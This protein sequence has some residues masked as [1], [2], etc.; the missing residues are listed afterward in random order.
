MIFLWYTYFSWWVF[1]WFLMYILGIIPI[2][3]YIGNLMV[4][5]LVTLAII[6][7]FIYYIFISN[8]P[9]TNYYTIVKFLLL[10]LVIDIIPVIMLKKEISENSII[11]MLLVLIAY[12]ICMNKWK[13]CILDHYLNINFENI[14]KHFRLKKLVLRSN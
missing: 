6:C 1:I 4:F 3:S 10:L 13:I 8:K 5:I 7:N 9:L 12:C 11:L 2:S 14:S